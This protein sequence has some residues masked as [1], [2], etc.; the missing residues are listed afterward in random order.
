MARDAYEVLGVTRSATD[1]EIKRAY[2]QLARECHPDANPDDP[3]AADRFKEINAAYEAVRDPER[4]RQYDMFGPDGGPG[5]RRRG[6]PVRAGRVRAQRPLRRVL[7]RRRVR[8]PRTAGS[9]ARSRRRDGDGAHARRGRHRRPAHR[10]DAHAGRVRHLRRLRRPARHAPDALRALRRR[11]RG[12]PGP[13]V[14]ARPDH[15]RRPVPEVLRARHHHRAP[16]RDVPRRRPRRGHRSIDVEVPAGIDDAQRLRLAGRGPAAPRGGTPGDLFVAVRV[17]PERRVRAARRRPLAPTPG[18]DRAGRA[19][20][21]GRTSRRSTARARSRCSRVRSPA[22][23][24][25]LP[26]LGVPSL[27]TG[28][29]GDLV[30]EVDVQVPTNLNP[31]QAELLAQLARAPRRRG[32]A[33]ARGALLAHPVGLPAVTQSGVRLGR[34]AEDAAAAHVRRRPRRHRRDHRRRRSSPPT[35]APAARRRA[36]HRRRRRGRWRRYEIEDVA[37][38]ALRLGARSERF[39]EPEL[40]PA[41]VARG[42]AHEG[43]RARHRR[44]ALHRAR[45]GADRADPDAAVRRALG[46][47]AGRTGACSGCA[48]PRAKRPRSRGERACPR[49]RRSP[50]SPTSRRVPGVVVADRGGVAGARSRSPEPKISSTRTHTFRVRCGMDCDRRAR[51]RA[52]SR[53]ARSAWNIYRVSVSDR[54]I[55]RAETAP[56]VGG[57]VIARSRRARCAESGR[58]AQCQTRVAHVENAV[59]HDFHLACWYDPTQPHARVQ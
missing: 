56:I 22:R 42:R 25:R 6:Q 3:H 10:R 39:E 40:V 27:R 12:A 41:R 7:Q 36:R 31:E 5:A 46:R 14:A 1:D 33:A 9:A 28:R 45:R 52:R 20:R 24:I 8:R 23:G 13:Q 17:A 43:G 37:P 59:K 34:P 35:G 54:H 55:L 53:R 4:R 51:R 15:D 18:V 49:S 30:L 21:A 48:R 58:C 2:R 32:H 26:G 44:R 16:V 11:R 50:G 19:R 57:R 29:R 47:G 38:G